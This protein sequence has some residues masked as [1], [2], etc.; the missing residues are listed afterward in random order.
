MADKFRKPNG[1]VDYRM[2]VMAK[3]S[4][5]NKENIRKVLTL[6]G[7]NG[8]IGFF[9]RVRRLEFWV[10]II[11]FAVGVMLA[12]SVMNGQAKDIIKMGLEIIK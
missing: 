7:G 4:R 5:E 9:E 11:G 10:R 2:E 8:G 3:E 1:E 6:L 12:A